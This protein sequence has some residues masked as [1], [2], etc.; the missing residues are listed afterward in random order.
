MTSSSSSV[1]FSCHCRQI[2]NAVE[3]YMCKLDIS[4]QIQGMLYL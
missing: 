3:Y 4:L 2:N 1:Q